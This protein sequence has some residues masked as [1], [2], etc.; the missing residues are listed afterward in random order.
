MTKNHKTSHRRIIFIQAAILIW[1]L[2]ACTR[3][4]WL[5][6]IEHEALQSRAERQQQ[7]TIDLS[8]TRG[9]IHDRNGNELAR[10]VKVNSLY[11]SPSKIT[12]PK[13]VAD[14]LSKLLDIDRDALYNRLK[15]DKV[16]V[17]VKRKLSEE[18]VA[19]V[20]AMSISGLR[21]VPEM[22]R[23][24]MNG[25]T[26]AHMLGFVDIEEAG[27]SGVELTYDKL[28]KGQGGRLL[29][30]VDG[31]KNSYDHELEDSVPGADITL[32]IDVMIQ[33]YVEKAL[34]EAVRANRARGGTAV[35]LRPSTGE[36]LALASYPTFDP[37]NLSD[38]KDVE[39]RNRAIETPFE[40]GSIFKLVTYSAALEERL[41]TPDSRIDCGGGQI[42]IADRVIRDKPYGMLTAAQALAKSSNIA[43]IKIGLRLGKERL[44][45]YIDMYGF[46]QRT[47]VELPAESRGLLR[48][49]SKWEATSMGSIPMGHEIG[50]TAL[51]AAA[52]FAAIANGGEWVQPHLVS[53]V[54]S[55]SGH[56]LEENRAETHRIV[57][58]E[59]A[60]KLTAMLED[61][62][63]RGTGKR[64]QV[65]GYRAAG[66]TGTAQKI[67]P[68]TGRYSHVLHLASFA[69]FAPVSNP[70]I[71]CLV[72]IDEP[73]VAHYGGE[74]AAPVFAKIVADALHI[75]GIPPEED[76]QAKLVAGDFQVYDIPWSI[77]ENKDDEAQA[78][79]S[80]PAIDIFYNANT[81]EAASKGE[82]SVV[83]P[84]LTG[85]GIREALVLCA[86]SGLKV[87]A[88]GNGVVASQDPQPGALVAP[89]TVCHL[90]LAKQIKRKVKP[91]TASVTTGT[92]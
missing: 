54:T 89:E 60:A 63:V 30:N 46:G 20:E 12:D 25:S 24:Y 35:V 47:G 88:S 75:L 7:F 15:S 65:Q 57:S 41:I 64:A 27:K 17:A 38:L 90:K 9:I 74:V 6:V 48:E 45:H 2:A 14:Q 59:T 84:D 69:G 49:V 37:N 80:R 83:V 34:A 21:F 92:H 85:R 39:R 66:K 50:V 8:P 53:R 68:A 1:A 31:F 58:E 56:I 32:T 40:P 43:A 4:V 11:A 71:V 73:K 42:R 5:Q 91:E 13:T 52:A 16:L 51:Q 77:V 36:I 33:H 82:G 23:F 81:G 72:S 28:I 61:V 78:S 62:V 79:D 10:S 26:A 22:K 70:E 76:P 55:S 29:L 18:E 44:A 67:D 87:K 19:D 86:K 3:L